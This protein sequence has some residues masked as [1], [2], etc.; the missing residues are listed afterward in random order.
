MVEGE[1]CA[2]DQESDWQ[3]KIFLPT[4]S[5]CYQEIDTWTSQGCQ[6]TRGALPT[7][8]ETRNTDQGAGAEA[9]PDLCL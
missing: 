8:A 2:W 9:G 5:C 6:K 3:N 7:D 4:L 1:G